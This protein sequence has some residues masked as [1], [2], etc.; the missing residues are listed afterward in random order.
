MTPT[1]ISLVGRRWAAEAHLKAKA[2]RRLLRRVV[3]WLWRHPL[4]TYWTGS[5]PLLHAAREWGLDTSVV[6]GIVFKPFSI[7]VPREIP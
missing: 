2:R 6:S 5:R 1:I 7:S 3:P 4:S